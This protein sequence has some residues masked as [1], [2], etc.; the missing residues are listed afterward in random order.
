MTKLG[1]VK[2]RA[3][4]SRDPIGSVELDQASREVSIVRHTRYTSIQLPEL[5]YIQLE[6]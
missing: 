1:V 4:A 3:V 2:P 5:N 6:D